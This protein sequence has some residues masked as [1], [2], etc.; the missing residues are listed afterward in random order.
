MLKQDEQ[1]QCNMS[2]SCT[3][4]HF[5]MEKTF[6][7]E[8]IRKIYFNRWHSDFKRNKIIAKII[9]VNFIS[10]I[11]NSHLLEMNLRW[12]SHIVKTK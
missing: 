6:S 2:N 9:N 10:N 8:V 4:K 7:T 3:V 1:L 11:Q 12:Y 5:L